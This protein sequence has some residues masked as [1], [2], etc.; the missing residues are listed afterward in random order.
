MRLLRKQ[1]DVPK[2]TLWSRIPDI[3]LMDV[4][5]IESGG[6]SAGSLEQLEQI[7]LEGDVGVPVTLR[8]VEEGERRA[9][10]GLVKTETEFR[11]ALADG[12]SEALQTGKSDPR[13]VVWTGEPAII[14]GVG[15]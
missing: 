14:L 5:V 3:A 12:V 8:R 4:A 6:V 11:Q 15:V 9:K 13:L 2:R 7:L 1:G 10:R